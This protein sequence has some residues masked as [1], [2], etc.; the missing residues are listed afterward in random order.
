MK[1]EAHRSEEQEEGYRLRTGVK[2]DLTTEEKREI[3]RPSSSRFLLLFFFLVLLGCA[4]TRISSI[5]TGKERYQITSSSTSAT[6]I[7]VAISEFHKEATEVCQGNY[8]FIEE[9]HGESR[10]ADWLGW[11]SYPNFTFIGTVQCQ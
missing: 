3:D 10:H 9:W 1:N 7:A 2:V 4:S 5:Q 6:P 11:P 8:R